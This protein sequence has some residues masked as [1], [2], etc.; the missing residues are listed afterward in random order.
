MKKLFLRILPKILSFL[1]ILAI[2]EA[3]IALNEK[4]SLKAFA[5][6]VY[7]PELVT[8]FYLT[9]GEM[10]GAIPKTWSPVW[11]KNQKNWAALLKHFAQ[12]DSFVRGEI[13]EEKTLSGITQLLQLSLVRSRELAQQ[14]KW[15]EVQKIWSDWFLFA[16][17]FPYEESSLIG[18][19]FTG[20]V[21]SLLLDEVEKM[22]KK[23]SLE[24]AQRP[25]LRIWFLTLRAPWPIDRIFVSEAKRLLPPPM[26]TVANAAASAFQ[27]NPYQSSEQVLKKVKG[28]EANEAALLKQIWK[29]AD[30]AMMKNEM[31]R[32]GKIKLRLAL[33]EFQFKNKAQTPSA[34]ALVKAGLIDSI[35][36]DYN[37]GK[38][39]DLSSL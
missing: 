7:E 28:G 5:N 3:A 35:P 16:A 2:S 12:S 30:I 21:R 29:D 4:P 11:K 22:Q 32:I 10:D 31:T 20:V 6:N 8:N 33:A 15:V 36:I 34:E 9:T 24:I 25:E 17:D 38:P 39:L 1:M 26:M 19:K 18:M 37:N 13:E 23:Y 14:A 27:K